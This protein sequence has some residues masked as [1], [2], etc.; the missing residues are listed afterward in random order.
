MK[1]WT[2][3]AA[4]AALMLAA[5]SQPATKGPAAPPQAVTVD[6]P[7]GQYTLDKNH[8]TVT[9]RAMHFGLA[10]YTLRFDRVDGALTF[11]PANPTQSSV[12]A[13]VPIASLSTTYS[14][15]R[16][17]NAELQNSEWL[18]AAG[19]PV[20]TFRSTNV[21]L[22]GANTGRM[23]GDLT[24]RGQTH[25]ATFDVTFNR[26]YR[27]HPMGAPFAELG[28]S[29]HGVIKRSDYGLRVLQPP[30]GGDAGVSDDVEII[31]EAEFQQPLA[32][33]NANGTP[34]PAPHPDT[35]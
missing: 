22:T 31:I 4:A 15:D 17:F 33:Q 9:V 32:P 25:P 27:Q 29:A 19:F 34:A 14:G 10:H 2:F 8:S 20:A 24:I 7:A 1:P 35:N 11:D 6:A 23:T 12:T 26:A 16:D 5:C 30:A 28:F 13:S 21:E 18:N 3:A